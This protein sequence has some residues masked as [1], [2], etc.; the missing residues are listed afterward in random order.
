MSLRMTSH[1]RIWTQSICAFQMLGIDLLLMAIVL[2]L[3]AATDVIAHKQTIALVC[4]GVFLLWGIVWFLQM[5]F[6][7]RPVKEYLQLPHWAVWI[8]CSAFVFYGSKQFT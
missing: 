4:S 5:A 8:V 1:N 7:K 2:Y 6:L 3:L